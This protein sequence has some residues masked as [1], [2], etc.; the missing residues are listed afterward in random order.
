LP[1]RWVIA[2]R[3]A[4]AWGLEVLRAEEREAKHSRALS[5]G[6]TEIARQFAEEANGDTGTP[7]NQAV[8]GYWRGRWLMSA[9]GALAERPL[10]AI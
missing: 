5:E 3:A 6:D 7:T 2:A 9:I 10:F 1:N 4:E 8:F